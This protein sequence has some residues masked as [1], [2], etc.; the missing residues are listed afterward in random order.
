[1]KAELLLN[2]ISREI[3]KDVIAA[4]RDT[5]LPRS[6]S[7]QNFVRPLQ[8]VTFVAIVLSMASILGVPSLIVDV[9]G[10]LCGCDKG[11]RIWRR[12]VSWRKCFNLTKASV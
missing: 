6:F 12:E 4:A 3:S 8:S 1:M 10:G 9:L 7:M 2:S 5:Q 11:P